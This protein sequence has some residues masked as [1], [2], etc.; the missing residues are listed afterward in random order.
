MH[1]LQNTIEIMGLPDVETSN[2][3]T[4]LVTDEGP[5]TVTRRTTARYWALRPTRSP[6]QAEM[7]FNHVT[8]ACEWLEIDQTAAA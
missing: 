4:A 8:G 2:K 5:K 6:P 3:P 1:L 7:E